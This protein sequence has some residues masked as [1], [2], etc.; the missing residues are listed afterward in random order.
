MGLHGLYMTWVLGVVSK[1]Q[2]W[3]CAGD[4]MTYM[5]WVLG[6]VSKRLV[7]C[8]GLHDLGFGCSQQETGVQTT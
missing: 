7:V 6:V 4:Y 5:T 2:L 3:L 8:R 1:R